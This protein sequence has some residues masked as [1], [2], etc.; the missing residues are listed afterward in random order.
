MTD[1]RACLRCSEGFE[2][3]GRKRLCPECRTRT[4]TADGRSRRSE[5]VERQRDDMVHAMGDQT[6][7]A[8]IAE[9]FRMMRDDR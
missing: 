6:R 5:G 9:G 1:L 7:N 3:E 8:R 2:P 4:H